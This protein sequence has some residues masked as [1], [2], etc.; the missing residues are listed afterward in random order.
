MVNRFVDIY[1]NRRT[2]MEKSITQSTVRNWMF[3][4]TKNIRNLEISALE[5]ELRKTLVEQFVDGVR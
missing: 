4:I 1:I 3:G 2:L 5:A